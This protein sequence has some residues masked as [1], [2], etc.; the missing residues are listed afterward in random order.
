MPRTF[1]GMPPFP[2]AAR[3]ALADPQLRRN[4]AHATSTIRE[5]RARVVAEVEDWED[6]RVQA[7]AVKDDTLAHLDTHLL[8]LE[9]A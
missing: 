6:L 5:K 4:L 8:A 1:V 2:V 9:A 3:E 7:A